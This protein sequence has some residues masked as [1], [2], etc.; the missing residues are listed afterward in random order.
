MD[1]GEE[2]RDR[3]CV[4]QWER[5]VELLGC[6][7]IKLIMAEADNAVVNTA[8]M[9]TPRHLEDAESIE[10][11]SHWWTTFRNYYRRDKYLGTFLVSTVKWDPT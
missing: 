4:S 3:H 5:G 6:G 9:P 11:L 8:R 1:R 2:P 7:Q 10:S